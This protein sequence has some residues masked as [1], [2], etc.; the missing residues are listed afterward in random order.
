MADGNEWDIMLWSKTSCKWTREKN[1]ERRSMAHPQCPETS[2]LKGPRKPSP[3]HMDSGQMSKTKD[4]T[5]SSVQLLQM[6]RWIAIGLCRTNQA[7]DTI[8]LC[9]ERKN[10]FYVWVFRI[11]E[12]ATCFFPQLIEFNMMFP[13][14]FCLLH[15]WRFYGSVSHII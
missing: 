5:Q 11:M 10:V 2:H 13:L 6:C 1:K 14:H 15:L 9:L 12:T 4:N 7:Y 8:L 3:E